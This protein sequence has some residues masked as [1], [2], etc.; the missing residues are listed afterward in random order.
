[1]G[2]IHTCLFSDSML[3][4]LQ[5]LADEHNVSLLYS[6]HCST[7]SYSRESFDSAWLTTLCSVAF[8]STGCQFGCLGRL[9]MH[10]TRGSARGGCKHHVGFARADAMSLDFT[11]NS[12]IGSVARTLQTG[13]LPLLHAYWLLAL[14]VKLLRQGS[15]LP[16]RSNEFLPISLSSK[17]C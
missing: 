11:L 10:A 17:G 2:I 7:A 16:A 15:Q 5:I 1:M 14:L 4:K 3:W 9:L 8:I 12:A 13:F 6:T